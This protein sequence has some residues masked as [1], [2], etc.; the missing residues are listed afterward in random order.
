MG[1][2]FID[3]RAPRERGQNLVGERILRALPR[4][5]ARKEGS[6]VRFFSKHAA[7][8]IT[9]RFHWRV[10][11]DE[12][13]AVGQ[14]M[15]FSGRNKPA[16]T[17]QSGTSAR[18]RSP[19]WKA[20]ELL[21][22][23]LGSHG[24]QIDR[25]R[26]ARI[27]HQPRQG[28]PRDHVQEARSPRCERRKCEREAEI[29]SRAPDALDTAAR[30]HRSSRTAARRAGGSRIISRGARARSCGRRRAFARPGSR[31]P[32]GSYASSRSRRSADHLAL[33]RAS[34]SHR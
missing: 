9:S 4:K 11:P 32:T 33:A 22:F 34:L 2:R 28:G 25:T 10:D 6:W 29:S 18:L 5:I 27:H 7:P 26:H 12:T 24:R 8:F 3:D 23:T 15:A 30:P 1:G 20:Q 13:R 17:S 19:L 31:F 16:S 21:D 14:V